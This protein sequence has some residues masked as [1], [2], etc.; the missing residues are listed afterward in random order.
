ML[1]IKNCN[2]WVLQTVTVFLL[3]GCAPSKFE[4][5]TPPPIHYDKLEDYDVQEMLAKIPKPDRLAPI[6]VILEGDYVNRLK[7][8][9]KELATHILLVPKEYA[10]IGGVVKLAKTYKEIVIEQEILIN[11][12]I[13]QINALREM[14]VLERQKAILY[15]EL[16]ADSENAYRQEQYE[17]NRDNIL[18][19][20]GMYIITIGSIIALAL[21]L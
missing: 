19:R 16:W 15:K 13:A 14:L 10:K 7:K 18:N 6:Y 5:Y 17:H 2:L 4:P 9:Q 1:S 8:D 12:Y 21:A 11:T 20:T 3:F